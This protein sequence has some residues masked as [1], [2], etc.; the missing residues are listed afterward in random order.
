VKTPKNEQDGGI[1]EIKKNMREKK[2]EDQGEV[3]GET[4][5]KNLFDL[6]PGRRGGG[7]LNWR[8]VRFIG[9]EQTFC[10]TDQYLFK[11]EGK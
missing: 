4:R 6:G 1:T 10:N 9:F 8:N 11:E 7:Y 5:E 3:G 2:Y